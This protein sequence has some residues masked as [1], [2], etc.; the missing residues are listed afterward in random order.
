M[1]L[2]MWK[3]N[4][5]NSLVKPT[6]LSRA[7]NLG[8]TYSEAVIL[9]FLTLMSTAS[10]ILGLG[11]F[12]P[13]FQFIRM[14]GDLEA[15]AADT[16][17]WNYVIN[18]FGYLNIEISLILLLSLSFVFFLTR[19]IFTYLRLLYNA[20]VKQ[21]LVQKQRNYVF[22]HYIKAN[23]SYH[24][25]IHVGNLLN[26]IQTEVDRAVAGIMTPL[27]L[28]VYSIMCLGYLVMLS[29][30]SLQMTL[31]SVLVFLIVSLI[32]RVWIKRSKSTGRKLVKANTLMSEFL[33]GRLRSPRLVRLSG[34]E[35]AEK[36]E[37]YRLTLTQRK[38]NVL[39]VIL[40]TKTETVMEPIIIGLSLVLLYFS[41]T[42]LH[43]QLEVIGLYLVIAMRL[44]PI[45]T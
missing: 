27:E 40:K 30:L 37:F 32:P 4:K 42:V 14:D 15:L 21:R 43:L 29:T 16:N 20:T 45:V 31:L 22:N 24:D 9:V 13:I 17:I 44:M 38:H 26:I 41:H 11:I 35:N 10:E 39:S 28:L 7:Q 36:H 23:T 1:I 8:I 18:A 3:K 33:V 2:C 19:Q 25:S 6:W 12:L 5:K 34:T